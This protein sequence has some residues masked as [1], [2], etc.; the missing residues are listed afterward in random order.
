M[1]SRHERDV[2]IYLLG[3]DGKSPSR[4]VTEDSCCTPDW[5]PD[6]R[7]LLFQTVKGHIHEIGAD[8]LSEEPLTFGADLQHEARYSPDGSMAVF[9][10]APSP[11]GPWQIC[12]LDLES[13]D[14]DFVQ[15]TRKGSNRL[16]DWHALEKE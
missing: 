10:R 13:D 7:K 8:G 12:I 5:S 3:P 11:Q 1:A 2:A 16:P 15:I 14:L 9:C 4:L 6:G